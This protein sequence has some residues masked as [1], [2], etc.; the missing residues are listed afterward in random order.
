MSW[1]RSRVAATAVALCLALTA[2]G[3]HPLYGRSSKAASA[4]QLASVYVPPLPDR[5]GQLVHTYLVR[6][7]NPD[8]RSGATRY[9]LDIGLTSQVTNL[10]IRKDQTAT[11]ANLTLSAKVQLR[12][13]ASNK[14]VYHTTS[15]VVVSYNLA[16]ARFATVAAKQDA[17]ERAARTI[18]DEITTQIAVF[19]AG[20]KHST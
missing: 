16:E 3:F 2:C 1:S 18:A 4:V 15:I 7:F 11:R 13:V 19:L 17:D 12:D 20:H 14:V 10:G 6:S 9:R 5:E 8:H